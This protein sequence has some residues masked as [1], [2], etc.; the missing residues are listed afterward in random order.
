[1]MRLYVS[2]QLDYEFKSRPM[3]SHIVLQIGPGCLGFR[4]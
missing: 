4:V 3:S 2:V 1:M